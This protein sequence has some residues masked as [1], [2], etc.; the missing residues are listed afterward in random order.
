MRIWLGGRRKRPWPRS[1][2]WQEYSTTGPLRSRPTSS[3]SV[4]ARDLQ[5]RT[6]HKGL[7]M[8]VE[9]VTNRTNKHGRIASLETL[10]SQ[11][12]L[13]FSRRQQL[14]LEQLRLFPQATHDDGPDALEMA[15]TLAHNYQHHVYRSWPV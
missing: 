3:Q 6:G 4:L 10:V 8:K 15:V 2:N 11:G 14:L 1:S 5:R 7:R 9:E 13:L 12:L